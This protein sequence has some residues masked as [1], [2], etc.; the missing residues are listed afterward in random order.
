MKGYCSLCPVDLGAVSAD[1][2][3][4]VRLYVCS[5]GDAKVSFEVQTSASEYFERTRTVRGELVR[6]RIHYCFCSPHESSCYGIRWLM[7]LSCIY[8][9]QDFLDLSDEVFDV[10]NVLTGSAGF[11]LD[12]EGCDL[13]QGLHEPPFSVEVRCLDHESRRGDC[14]DDMCELFQ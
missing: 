8:A 4:F 5:H 9:P 11:R 12:P 2:V 3:R 1:D 13:G 14:A 7:W 6:V 10:R